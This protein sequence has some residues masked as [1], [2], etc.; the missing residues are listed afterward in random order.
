MST[1]QTPQELDALKR[2][3]AIFGGQAGLAE[4]LDLKDRRNLWPYFGSGRRFP[5]ELCP[6]VERIT[7]ANGSPVLCE[8]LRPDVDWSVLRRRRPKSRAT[9]AA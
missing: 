1:K 5:A 8:E 2:A 7:T 3:A 6:K 9:V 4:A